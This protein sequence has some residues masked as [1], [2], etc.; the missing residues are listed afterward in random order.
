MPEF[1]VIS[2]QVGLIRRSYKVGAFKP[3]RLPDGKPVGHAF[4][5]T[6]PKIVTQAHDEHTVP[7]PVAAV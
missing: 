2:E 1:T 5:A 4:V 6:A 3:G 7:V